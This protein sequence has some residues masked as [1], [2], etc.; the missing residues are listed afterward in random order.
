MTI[1]KLMLKL[2]IYSSALVGFFTLLPL[3]QN[4]TFT[5][6]S[7]TPPRPFTGPLALNDKLSGISK[8]FEDQIVGPEGLLYHN[9]TLYTTLHYGHV[10]KIVNNEIV[11][12]VKFGKVCDGLYEEHVCGRPLG[13]TMDKSGFL[14]VADAY[15][16][17]FKVN[18]NSKFYGAKE[19]L[20]SMDEDIDGA[21]PKIPN[22]VV[23]TSDGTVYWTDSDSNY[24]LYDGVYTLFVDGTGRLLKYDPKTKKNTVLMK[25]LQFANGVQLSNDES[26]L[27]V[28]ET[29]KYRV[30]KYYLKGP[31]AGKS[32]IFID[33]LPGMPDNIKRNDKGSFYIP[34]VIARIP[35]FDNIGEYPTIRMMVTKFLGIIDFTLLKINSL[36][37]NLY[38]KEAM[39]WVG[40]FES[41]SLIKSLSKQRISILKVNEK[42]QLL[43]SYHSLDGKISG[44]CDVEVIGD[45]LYLGSPFN[46]FLGVVKIPQGF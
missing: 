6:Y 25:N 41:M 30:L 36:Y 21:R 37:P 1:A 46:N 13:L 5:E 26:F 32:E 40:H 14:Y 31:K 45:K 17:I 4:V 19:Q 16:G 9:N 12:V 35:I 33:G 34:L 15:Y 23:V 39:R 43:S 18:L 24:K 28:A 27:L 20:V 7:V 38:C 8:L 42:G 22:S 2:G 11:P 3:M 29:E 10:V 44:I